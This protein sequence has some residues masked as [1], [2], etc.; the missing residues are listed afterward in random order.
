MAVETATETQRD[1]LTERI[2]LLARLEPFRGLDSQELEHVA[3]A[4]TVQFAAPGE[5]VQVESGRPGA[6]LYVVRDGTLEL[7]HK[8]ATVAIISKG[9][10]FGHPTLLTGLPPEFTTRARRESTLWC[11]PK[12][13][14]TEILSRPAG[15]KFVAASLRERLIQ[16]ARTMRGAPDV[17]V[18]S[19]ASLVRTAPLFCNP[20][21]TIREAA[22]LMGTERASA[23]LVRTSDGLGIV[24]D[25]DLRDKVV[26]GDVCRD[27]PV[28]GIMTMPVHTVD[29]DAS[30]STAPIQMMAA[31]VGNLPVIDAGGEVVGVLSA[32]NL[33]S[34]D[35]RSPFALRR[36]IQGARDEDE[37]VAASADLPALFVDLLDA[38][39]DAP[40]LTRILTVLNDAM[41]LRLIEM[42]IDRLGEPPVAYAWL[43]FGS[44]ARNELTL[45]SDQDNGL[46]YDDS[47]DPAVPEYF[48]RLATDVNEGLGRCGFAI[49]PHG[50]VARNWKWRLS[51]SKWRAV[52]SRSLEDR[53]PNR[54]ARASI[55]FD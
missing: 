45:A 36:R 55:A 15:V 16:V 14:A 2:G 17:R 44:A 22:R 19:V 25:H 31:G 52:F 35:A 7:A 4:I 51:L 41:T 21:T 26:A 9:E 47:D 5:V 39:V 38:G 6:F 48:R 20:H 40:A 37:L 18:R 13:I 30:A 11:I 3:S 53:D 10:V 8:G 23:L 1:P 46:A 49:D 27:A 32:K 43:V 28:S 34:L 33:M 50:T 24:T 12:D 29:A 54:L 42:A